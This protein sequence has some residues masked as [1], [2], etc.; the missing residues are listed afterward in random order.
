MRAK[1]CLTAREQIIANDRLDGLTYKAI[2]DNH[3]ISISTVKTH[4]ARIFIKLH[5]TSSL[6]LQRSCR[7]L[8]PRDLSLEQ[9]RLIQ[10]Q[11]RRMLNTSNR[12]LDAHQHWKM[13]KPILQPCSE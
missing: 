9:V 3:G 4:L 8:R 6:D 11:V 12:L 2:A 7:Q 1:D 5:I 13:C 10:V